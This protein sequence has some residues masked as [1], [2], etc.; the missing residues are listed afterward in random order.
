[1]TANITSYEGV[2]ITEKGNLPLALNRLKDRE[3]DWE[4][5]QYIL[6]A[7]RT[8]PMLSSLSPLEYEQL[9]F[10]ILL[11]EKHDYWALNTS[12][13]EINRLARYS[14]TMRKYREFLLNYLVKVREGGGM[15]EEFNELKKA[16]RELKD[17]GEIRIKITPTKV[18]DVEYHVAEPEPSDADN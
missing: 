13:E 1:M 17:G 3:E 6:K 12:E 5:F 4:R 10:I 11:I 8:D 14:E 2:D 18:V 15:V 9:A 16:I 7:L